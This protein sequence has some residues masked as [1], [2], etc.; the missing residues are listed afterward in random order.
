MK[1]LFLLAKLR[2]LSF[3]FAIKLVLLELSMAASVTAT[4]SAGLVRG[5]VT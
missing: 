2:S 1:S 5:A 3:R 4:P